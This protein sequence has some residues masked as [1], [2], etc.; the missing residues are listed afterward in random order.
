MEL[1][2][3]AEVKHLSD[4]ELKDIAINRTHRGLIIAAS[5]KELE[6]RGITL[7]SEELKQKDLIKNTRIEE[8][9]KNNKRVKD[10]WWNY[11]DLIVKDEDAP[12][13]YSR[14]HIFLGTALFSVLFGA[15]LF[16]INLSKINK[17]KYI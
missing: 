3:E 6:L 13:L 12:I 15:I 2:F 14:S 4:R 17:S 1:D 10:S 7:A 5:K 8:A 9:I 16:S 11:K